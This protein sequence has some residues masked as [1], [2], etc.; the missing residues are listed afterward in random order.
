MSL[1]DMRSISTQWLIDVQ[2]SKRTNEPMSNASSIGSTV[3]IVS[4][5]K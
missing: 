2:F 3:Q 1:P 4:I 5:S